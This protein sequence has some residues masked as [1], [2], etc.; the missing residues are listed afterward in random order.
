MGIK[1]ENISTAHKK[2]KEASYE[3]ILKKEIILFGR[4]F[5]NK[6]KEQFYSELGVLL[7]SGV[8]LKHSLEIIIESQ[9]KDKDKELIENLN[10]A[11][12]QG[13]SFADALKND[14]NF[15]PYEFHA[16]K[17]GE[18]TG[19]LAFVTNDLAEYYTRRNEQKRQIVSSLTYPLIVLFTAFL[20]VFFM[21]K[22]V[23]PMFE[24]IFKQNQVELPFL[25][26]VIVKFS[27][28]LEQNGLIFIISMLA[29][30]FGIRFF[31]KKLWFRKYGGEL[32]LNFPV[33]GNYIRKVYLTRFIHT[34]MLLTNSKIPVINGLSMVRKM[35]DFYPL[36]NSLK[37]IEEEILK[38]ERM[39]TS[40]S[41]HKIFDKKIIA[42][43]KVAEETNQTEFIFQRLYDQYSKEVEYQSKAITNFLNPLLTLMVGFIVGIILIAMYLPMFKLSSVI[44]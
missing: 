11:I 37:E 35:V 5:S 38:G 24:D 32:L 13:S 4:K 8:N 9:G 7:K 42:L 22:Y 36:Q 43:L 34:M 41:K 10:K 20:V 3:N 33:V 39:S 25:T 1:I 14:E 28:L 31:R 18:Q 19:Q 30:I 26:K 40:F 16:I 17:I 23:V 15:T 2:N 21:L 12:L 44:G 27:H 6:K 29:V